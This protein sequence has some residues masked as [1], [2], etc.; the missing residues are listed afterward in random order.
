MAGALDLGT[1]ATLDLPAVWL[2]WFDRWLRDVTDEAWPRVR[3]FAMG[4][5]AWRDA[6]AWPPTDAQERGFYLTVD[7]SLATA[8][9]VIGGSR[10]FDY[11]PADPTPAMESLTG[12]PLPEWSPRE[13]GFL[14]HRSDVLVFTSDPLQ[15]PLDVA[16][17]VH[18]HVHAASSAVDTDF[19]AVLADVEPSGRSILVSQGIVRAAFRDSL[20]DPTPLIPGECYPFDIELADLG[21]VFQ[22]G[23]RLRL[24]VASCL[25]PYYHPNPNTGS[26]YEEERASDYVPATQ[27]IFAGTDRP[28]RLVLFVRGDRSLGDG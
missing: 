7:G 28:S 1:D 9:P 3:Y 27:A 5:N 23:H 17:P 6:D 24:T 19:A 2:A 14:E 16:G 25:F 15:K 13:L 11:D 12:D 8:P 18:L 4:E 21:H 20:T 22:P 26:S 10:S